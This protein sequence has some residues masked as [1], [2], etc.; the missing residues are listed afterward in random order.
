MSASVWFMIGAAYFFAR[1][2]RQHALGD[3]EAAEDVDRGER[4]RDHAH[5]LREVEQR[6][7]RRR[8]ARRR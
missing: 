4:H 8:S 6:G 5:D 2:H 1:K 7:C 3:D